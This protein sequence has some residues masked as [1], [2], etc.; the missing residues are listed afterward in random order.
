MIACNQNNEERRVL[1]KGVLDSLLTIS[2]PASGCNN[3]Q[4]IMEEGLSVEKGIKQ[5][6]LNLKTKKVPIVYDPAVI[7]PKLMVAVIKLRNQMPCK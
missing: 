5:S 4:K 7:N 2:L 3:C 6:M 1:R